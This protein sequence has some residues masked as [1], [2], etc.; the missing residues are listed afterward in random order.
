MQCGVLC[1]FPG[2]NPLGP[3]ARPLAVTTQMAPGLTNHP[4]G[5]QNVAAIGCPKAARSTMAATSYTR[6]LSP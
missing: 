6:L 2:L 3:G 4:R 1:H 5:R